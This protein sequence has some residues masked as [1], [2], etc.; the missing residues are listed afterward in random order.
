[1]V[2][3]IYRSSIDASAATEPQ[4][5]MVSTGNCRAVGFASGVLEKV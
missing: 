3:A 2:A 5:E 1:M 4:R